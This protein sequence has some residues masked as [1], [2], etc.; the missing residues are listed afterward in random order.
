MGWREYKRSKKHSNPA[1]AI[2]P[3]NSF[4]TDI[5]PVPNTHFTIC[6]Q[7]RALTMYFTKWSM[8]CEKYKS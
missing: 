8:A 7:E 4:S 3:C 2:S 5:R 6:Q 1:L